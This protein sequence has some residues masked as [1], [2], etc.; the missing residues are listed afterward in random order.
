MSHCPACDRS[1]D[2]AAGEAVPLRC[3][4][5]QSQVLGVYCD[6]DLIGSGAMGDVF[7][8]RRPNMGN[9]IV[10][11]KV[12][13]DGESRACS[14]FE[15]EIAASARLRHENIVC[16][17]DRGEE[18]GKP[19]LVMEFV[20]G[21]PLS[22]VIDAQHPLAP[23]EAARILR[24]VA[25]GLAHAAQHQI[26]NRDIKPDNI[27]IADDG[28]AK[29]LDYGLALIGELDGSSDRVTRNGT[30]LGTPGFLAPEQAN[31][32]RGVNIE[33]DVYSLGC[34]A[35]YILTRRP[36]FT[37]KDSFAILK[38]HAA[39]PRPSVR[40]KRPDVDFPLDELI[41]RMMA[42]SPD[43][44][45][46]PKEL[47]Q[48]LDRLIPQLSAARPSMASSMSGMIDTRCPGCQQ[49]FHLRG[50]LVGKR[51]R[52]P[53]K[54]CGRSFTIE[55]QLG[56]TVAYTDTPA[57]SAPVA[58]AIDLNFTERP[59]SQP[60]ELLEAEAVDAEA[61]DAEPIEA[62]AFD[63]EPVDA[64]ALDAEPLEAEAVD[65]DAVE[66]EPLEAEAIDAEAIDADAA[67]GALEPPPFPPAA[68]RP[69]VLLE[70][71]SSAPDT[72][73]SWGATAKAPVEATLPSTPPDAFDPPPVQHASASAWE[74]PPA[75][76]GQV[77]IETARAELLSTPPLPAQRPPTVWA[78]AENPA[79]PPPV[80][81]PPFPGE[82]AHELPPV[83]WGAAA[84]TAPPPA[85][86]APRVAAATGSSAAGSAAAAAPRRKRRR[87]IMAWAVAGVTCAMLSVSGVAGWQ[88]YQKLHPPPEVVWEKVRDSYKNKD[89]EKALEGFRKFAQD[90]PEDSHAA[91]VP[92]FLDL[93]EIGQPLYSDAGNSEQSL[94]NVEELFR[95]YRDQP[96][97][98]LYPSELY[99]ILQRLVE[100]FTEEATRDLEV[101]KIERAR[102]AFNLLTTIAESMEET[103]EPEVTQKLSAFMDER[104]TTIRSK[105]TL[106]D[107]LALLQQAQAADAGANPDDVYRQIAALEQQFPELLA[108]KDFLA[109]RDAAYQAEPRRVRFEPAAD[110]VVRAAS[111][112]RVEPRIDQRLAI[113]WQD[114][115]ATE[116][117][118]EQVVA[119]VS[120]GVLYVFNARGDLLWFRP[121]G[122]DS[123][124]LPHR[125]AATASSPAA[126]I[127][128][129]T[130]D[131]ALL[132][133]EAHTGR[134]LWQYKVDADLLAPLTIV[135][136]PSGRNE[137]DKQRGLLTTAD[138]Q[139]HALE[140]VLGRRIGQFH[141][142]Q[143]LAAVEG[144][145]DPE[146]HLVY[147]PADSKR[148]FAINALAIDNP[149]Q[150]ACKA[151]LFTEH[152]SGSLRS[153]L[154]VV[155]RGTG[156]E[157]YLILAEASDLERMRLRVFDSSQTRVTDPRAKPIKGQEIDLAGWSWFNPLM[158]ADRMT[159]VTDAGE[160]AVFGINLDNPQEALY[161]IIDDKSM[162]LDIHD[163]DRYRSLAV[164]SDDRYLWVMAGGS[165]R[166]LKLDVLGQRVRQVW[167]AADQPPQ[168][169]G[170]PLHAAQLDERGDHAFVSLMSADGGRFDFV[171]IDAHDGQPVW[172]RQ[173]GVR[174]DGD[175]LLVG[176]QVL[177]VDHTGRTVL[178]D[179]ESSQDVY[180][181]SVESSLPADALRERTVIADDL[182][183]R[184]LLARLGEAKQ[185][186]LAALDAAAEN[187]VWQTIA[188]P[189]KLQGQP[190]ICGDYL[191]MPGSDG[192][193]HR[194]P[195][196]PGARPAIDDQP[197]YW[198]PGNRKSPGP[199]TAK[200]YAVG[201]RAI[202][203]AA[204]RREVRRLDLVEQNNITSWREGKVFDCEAPLMGDVL[205]TGSRAWATDEAG[206]VNFLDA[207]DPSKILGTWQLGGR[208]TSNPF[209]RGDKLLA[210]IEDRKLVAV[211][212]ES[213]DAQ[214]LW[215]TEP[216]KGRI[217][218]QPI[219]DGEV[220]L[221]ADDGRR[222]T[223]LKLNTGEPAWFVRL[224][225]RI[226]PAATAVPFGRD[227]ILVPL[228]DGTLSVVPRPAE[229][230]QLAG[231]ADSSRNPGE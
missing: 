179:P 146:S 68:Q 186:A 162:R 32:P 166:K 24:Q 171:A 3:P 92:F 17:F 87:P 20:A 15:R 180:Q 2:R 177:L 63:A 149:S 55:P 21:C 76:N 217:R 81:A 69:P 6:L 18:E 169:T 97:Y 27:L 19:Y 120:R 16:A 209:L 78:V 170:I 115:A 129:A 210:V 156:A 176:E 106:K 122:I 111:T 72:L 91:E 199:E 201:P 99:S 119:A 105:R 60:D 70:A 188:L 190:C 225:A 173:L 85:S 194:V 182:G 198:M 152:A 221:V 140:L 214:P 142:G 49:V 216:F 30:L 117:L 125:L 151:V 192:I 200:L 77:P 48:A 98:D 128:L 51:M 183:R 1:F 80:A 159:L 123:N 66:I 155:D 138:G 7:K 47:V 145:E 44:R 229:D 205:V 82:A 56:P 25:A 202:L 73:V 114:Q 41:Q 150:P 95:K 172:Q 36:P 38:Q 165:L 67:E 212:P 167:P 133:L 121:L 144:A 136:V 193:L 8:A 137:P 211:S 203:L 163:R 93:A 94:T 220:L 109:Q 33:A 96:V 65:A 28:T 228:A 134:P 108:N 135:T 184:Y 196:V 101:A 197:H 12:P 103:W 102:R 75:P 168:V 57:D 132:A 13:K 160:L 79:A 46:T 231:T 207:A 9:R 90:F 224:P 127:A 126:L 110:D 34:T 71:A 31:D 50:E 154:A 53:N 23:A 26:V 191:V 174:L 62:E 40:I 61:V 107:A 64:E 39:A 35:H 124:C 219:L 52:C 29:I 84:A 45:P 37:G 189:E 204:A 181:P 4:H 157:S 83:Q 131:N 215:T 58:A 206:K 118:S 178:I 226:G 11:I 164:D 88:I 112:S 42:V 153:K 158:A 104:E 175:P 227:R 43:A 148:V 100:R 14:R 187:L 223:A 141:T 230:K 130:D 5:C 185:I 10:A 54:L 208:P 86:A 222:V 89:W 218:G 113:V 161:R 116:E 139:I 213:G 59:V 143:P 195:L 74:S 22:D 147:F